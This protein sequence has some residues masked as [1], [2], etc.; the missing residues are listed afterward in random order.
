MQGENNKTWREDLQV[1]RLGVPRIPLIKNRVWI[2]L[3]LSALQA[4]YDGVIFAIR[5]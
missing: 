2:K 5:L 4:A 1:W 3:W